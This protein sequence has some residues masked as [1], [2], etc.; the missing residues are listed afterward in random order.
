MRTTE[1]DLEPR[2]NGLQAPG[3]SDSRWKLASHAADPGD[4]D[5]M[6]THA[7][8]DVA[9]VPFIKHHVED[10]GCETPFPEVGRQVDAA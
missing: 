10:V 7:V 9:V 4:P 2:V 1:K 8:I 3:L 5:P 6:F